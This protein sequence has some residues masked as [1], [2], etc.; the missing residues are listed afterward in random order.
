VFRSSGRYNLAGYANSR[1]DELLNKI[2]SEMVTYARDASLVSCPVDTG[3]KS[4]KLGE[5]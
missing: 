2:S 5:D 4:L 3:A 1:V